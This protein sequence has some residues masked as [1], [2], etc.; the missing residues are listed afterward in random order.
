MKSRRKSK[1][2]DQN[3]IV[4]SKIPY[5]IVCVLFGLVIGLPFILPLFFPWTKDYAGCEPYSPYPSV[6][7]LLILSHLTLILIFICMIF[8]ALI[9]KKGKAY[10]I[11]Y[12][13]LLLGSL[14]SFILLCLI[15]LICDYL[16]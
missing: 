1:M 14:F 7:R 2:S 3:K 11:H 6:R 5:Y 12:L 9:R 13:K 4:F 10:F 16:A 8:F 15:G